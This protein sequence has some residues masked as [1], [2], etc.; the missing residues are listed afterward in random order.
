MIAEANEEGGNE[1]GEGGA[2]MDKTDSDVS[3]LS[4]HESSAATGTLV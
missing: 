4:T 1:E 3:A 2:S